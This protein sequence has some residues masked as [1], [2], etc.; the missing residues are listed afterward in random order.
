MLQ[1]NI[2]FD[3]SSTSGKK[4]RHKLRNVSQRILRSKRR[5]LQSPIPN[6][7]PGKN[8]SC[9]E[10]DFYEKSYNFLVAWEQKLGTKGLQVLQEHRFVSTIKIYS[11]AKAVWPSGQ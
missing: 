8:P 2:I 6:E 1:Q 5:I 11:M 10:N 9:Q 3:R 4:N 7:Q